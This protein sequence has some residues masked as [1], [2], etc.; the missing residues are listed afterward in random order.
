MNWYIHVTTDITISYLN[1]GIINVNHNSL[2][3]KCPLCHFSMRNSRGDSQL[4]WGY[5]QPSQKPNVPTT[6]LEINTAVLIPQHCSMG[7]KA[8]NIIDSFSIISSRTN[9]FEVIN[10]TFI[11]IQNLP[12]N[13][14]FQLLKAIN[15]KLGQLYI[16]SFMDH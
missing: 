3:L 9:N 1:H 13:F 11:V 6:S 14:E 16:F 2:R 5:L 8:E 12:A 15:T 10:C 7:L 4:S